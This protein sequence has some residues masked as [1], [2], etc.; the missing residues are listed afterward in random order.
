MTY[1]KRLFDYL[2]TENKFILFLVFTLS[3]SVLAF[4]I[5]VPILQSRLIDSVS[6]KSFPVAP[7]I[8]A[9]IFSIVSILLISIASIL[10][11]ILMLK[12][13]SKQKLS[14][15]EITKFLSASF[16]NMAG[17]TG[18]YYGL[19]N[20]ANDLSFIAYPAI[21]NIALSTIQSCIILIVLYKISSV[22]LYAIVIVACF[23]LA[24]LFLSGKKYKRYA[25]LLRDAE[26]KIIEEA[27]SILSNLNVIN[28]FGNNKYFLNRYEENIASYINIKEKAENFMQMQTTL[29]SYIKA[30]CF[31]VFVLI[32]FREAASGSLTKGELIMLL[33]YIPLLIQP[34]SKYQYFFKIKK[35]I[36]ESERNRNEFMDECNTPIKN[37]KI[38]IPAVNTQKSLQAEEVCFS[39]K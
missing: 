30:V 6:S 31:S 29:L 39:Y 8:V 13:E 2:K 33:S 7:A 20:I 38:M 18:L 21:L 27:N 37:S 19:C 23:Y 34:L 28:R 12:Y 11:S 17:S 3:V 9:L 4:G 10:P 16:L 25:S 32:S 14:M 36:E 1:K 35:W 22:I 24:V 5:I 26:P 15:I